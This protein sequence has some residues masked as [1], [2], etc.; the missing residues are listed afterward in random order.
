MTAPTNATETCALLRISED[1]L[2]RLIRD[3][4][5]GFYRGRR[6]ARMFTAE[7]RAQIVEALAV[8]STANTTDLSVPGQTAL[9]AA[10]HRKS[11]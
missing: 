9:S 8:R 3:G 11:A 4:R 6:G 2:R 1:Q 7:D 5:V 10:R